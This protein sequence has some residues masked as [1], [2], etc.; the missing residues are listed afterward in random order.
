MA[1]EKT[2]TKTHWKQLTNPN[3]IGAYSLESGKDLTVQIIKVT[4]EIVKGEGGKQDECT[5]AT[6]KDQKPMILNVT[7]CKTITK[8]F[9]TPYIEEWAGKKITLFKAYTKLKGEDVEC[10]RI[11]DKKPEQTKPILSPSN[12]NWA[13]AIQAVKS[14]S[15]TIE[16]LKQKYEISEENKELI[17]NE[18]LQNEA[19]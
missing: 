3:Y 15:Y 5:I 10:L 18:V 7:N 1:N 2:G 19:V 8:L 17:L 11:R 4:K 12:P 13:K 9:E 16:S 14:G 6:L